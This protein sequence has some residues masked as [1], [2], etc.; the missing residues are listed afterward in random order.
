M[1][2]KR[3]QSFTCA[4][5]WR[6][7]RVQQ[8]QQTEVT[9]V[10]STCLGTLNNVVSRE[11]L[12]DPRDRKYYSDIY[13][14]W[15]PPWV[16]ITISTC[17]LSLYCYYSGH[18]SWPQLGDSTWSDISLDSLLVYCPHRKMEMWRFLSYCLV[19]S[20]LWQLVFNLS[21]QT[22]LGLPL[23]MVHGSARLGLIYG[24]GVLAGSLSTS[25]LDPDTCLIGASG[26]VYSLMAGHMA[27][28]VLNLS[29]TRYGH[30]RLIATLAVASVEV[31]VA[32]YRRY[33][34]DDLSSAPPLSYLAHI[35]GSLAGVTVGLVILNNF[36]QKLWER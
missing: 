3:T 8:K 24:A 28:I 30:T 18:V 35:S 12:T 21:L 7:K 31:G 10:N 34:E 29:T 20:S 36:Q 16:M 23:E 5:H 26:G 2:G 6:D 11:V 13:R 19:H 22:V 32:V 17:Q 15:P 4:V 33:D 14:C 9:R 25:V 1:S 27:N